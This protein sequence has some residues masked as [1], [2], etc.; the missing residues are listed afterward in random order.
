MVM[1][2]ESYN[3]QEDKS[4]NYKGYYP[5]KEPE[6]SAS[7]GKLLGYDCSHKDG[8]I[9]APVLLD[10]GPGPFLLNVFP[11]SHITTMLKFRLFHSLGVLSHGECINH[12]LNIAG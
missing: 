9:V 11:K 10:A 7:L 6:P 1:L 4:C 3:Y 5:Q 12:G 2:Y 8:N